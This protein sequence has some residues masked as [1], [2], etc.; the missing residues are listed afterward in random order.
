MFLFAVF[1]L[2]IT[3]MMRGLQ[4]GNAIPDIGRSQYPAL[5]IQRKGGEIEEGNDTHNLRRKRTD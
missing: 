2:L 3:Y 5:R 4:Y 1:F